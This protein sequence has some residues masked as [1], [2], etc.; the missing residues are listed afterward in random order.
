MN[1]ES[2]FSGYHKRQCATCDS[3]AWKGRNGRN[4][5]TISSPSAAVRVPA[6]ES[7]SIE[8]MFASSLRPLLIE[9]SA[10]MLAALEERVE[11][12]EEYC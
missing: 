5:L 11:A 4:K 3:V 12:F 1:W 10:A 2:Q 8:V 7:F 6:S 9:G